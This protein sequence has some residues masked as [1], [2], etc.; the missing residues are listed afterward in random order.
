MYYIK[1]GDVFTDYPVRLSN[2]QRLVF[3]LDPETLQQT[4]AELKPTDK[5]SYKLRAIVQDSPRPPGEG[6]GVRASFRVILDYLK[7]AQKARAWL[8]EIV[9]QAVALTQAQPEEIARHL[10]R[11]AARNQSDFFI[12]QRLQE[13]LDDDLDIFVKTDVLNAEQLLAEDAG[14]IPARALRVARVI[15]NVGRRIN[16]FLGVL[17]DFQKQ[18]WEKKK[19]VLSTRYVITLDRLDKLA[20]R[21]FVEANLAAILSNAAQIAEWQALGLGELAT[22]E[23]VRRQDS[24]FLPLPVDTLHFDE[25]FKWALLA[26]VTKN[27]ALDESLDGVAIHSDN[28]QA[29]NTLQEKYGERVKCVY[30]DPPYNTG[31]DGFPYKDAYLHASWLA[32][33]SDRLD[34]AVKL[35][36]RSGALFASI[37]ANERQGLEVALNH[38]FGRQ[39]RVEEIIWVQNSTKSQSPTYSNNHEYVEVYCR[40]LE[41]VKRDEKMFREPKPGYAEVMEL[42]ESLNSQYPSIPEIRQKITALFKQHEV[43]FRDELEEQGIDYDRALDPWKGLYNYRNAEYRDESGCLVSESDAKVRLNAH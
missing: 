39:N 37:D 28:W 21:G 12:H 6:P 36:Q 29:L 25:D 11:Y 15:R 9:T 17:E 16:A 33:I 35:I 27:H 43:E 18:L 1:S 31:G 10:R 34:V 20:G 30:I 2:G 38:N 32:M 42:V 5:A 7:G 4:R 40:N 8:E 19:L 26:A 14:Q 24:G 3:C 23:A 13:A 41:T 22:A